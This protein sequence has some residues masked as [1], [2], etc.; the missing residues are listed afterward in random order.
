MLC[1]GSKGRR[2]W[3]SKI[4]IVHPFVLQSSKSLK[5]AAVRAEKDYLLNICM[6]QLPS[7]YCKCQHYGLEVTREQ[8]L[9][10][11]NEIIYFH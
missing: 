4:V 6:S 9:K 1:M 11:F 7:N 8:R 3:K 10:V 5:K 2:D